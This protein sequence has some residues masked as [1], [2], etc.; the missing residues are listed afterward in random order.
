MSKSLIPSGRLGTSGTSPWRRSAHW[1]PVPGSVRSSPG[2]PVP[3]LQEVLDTLQGR[4]G[5]LLEVKGPALYPGIAEAIVAEL[6]C[7]GW[8][9][10]DA[11]AGRLVV[12]SFDWAFMK[13]FNTLAPEVP[14]GLLGG[15][16]TEAQIA[17]LASWADQINPHHRH[18]T[19]DF[20]QA[21]HDHGMVTW[22]YTVDDPQWMRE[23]VDLRVDGVITN[24]PE[25]LVDV[26]RTCG[27]AA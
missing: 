16:P 9:R 3:T 7:E 17:E 4:A 27:E 2:T 21:V 23:L 13:E 20:V 26:L 22:P 5:L 14:A 19:D 1:T 25:I 24:R 8:L 15:P 10:A 12:Q 18:V 6:D 11:R